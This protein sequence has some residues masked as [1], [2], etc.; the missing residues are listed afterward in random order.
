[1]S[2]K[3]IL[4]AAVVCG[5]FASRLAAEEANSGLIWSKDPASH[6]AFVA[7]K[8]LTSGPTYWV[9]ACPGNK[10]SGL[11]MLRRRDGERAGPAF[12]GEMKAGVPVIGAI[13]DNGYR[14]GR[15]KD[16][17]IGE[18]GDLDAQ[19]KIDAFN[20]AAKAAQTVSDQYARQ[21]NAASAKLYRTIVQQL[22]LQIE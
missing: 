14:V 4:S 5:P 13:D 10:A 15:F 20:V 7:P 12:Y 6:C 21:G 1:M 17:D 9:G 18:V 11:G 3:L 8:S 16:G 2:L 22:E 19:L